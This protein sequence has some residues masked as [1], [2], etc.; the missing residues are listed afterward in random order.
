MSAGVRSS[1]AR[2][3][4]EVARG[5]GVVVDAAAVDCEGGCRNEAGAKADR[6]QETIF[7][8]PEG[9]VVGGGLGDV[10]VLNARGPG[11]DVGA[12][13]FGAGDGGVD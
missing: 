3:V 6:A 9:D 10:M 4:F 7:D 5:R 1:C 13:A 2:A 12:L 11:E 8:A